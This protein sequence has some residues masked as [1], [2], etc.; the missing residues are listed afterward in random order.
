[1]TIFPGGGTGTSS[2]SGTNFWVVQQGARALPRRGRV[3][4][5]QR[6]H[7]PYSNAAVIQLGGTDT[8]AM[9]YQVVVKTADYAAL[10]ALVNTRATLTI[11]GESGAT[12]VLVGVGDAK[13]Y[14]EGFCTCTINAEF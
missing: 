7:I 2:F 8:P 5:Y 13:E 10:V 4:V 9:Q 3:S 11:N 6:D 1:M 14:A 12:A